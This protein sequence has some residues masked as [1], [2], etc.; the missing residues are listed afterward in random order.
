MKKI[1]LIGLIVLMASFIYS[2]DITQEQLDNIN[3]DT[4][5]LAPSSIGYFKSKTDN[6]V[7]YN[8]VEFNYLL[9]VDDGYNIT[10]RKTKL[11]IIPYA[12]YV[13]CKQIKTTAD[14]NTHIVIDSFYKYTKIEPRIRLSLKKYQTGT[15]DD[16]LSIN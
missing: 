7:I 11:N 2:A 13:Y 15:Q 9:K 16:A 8:V 6:P 5:N 10:R 1:I 12:D 3:L 4:Y 14:C